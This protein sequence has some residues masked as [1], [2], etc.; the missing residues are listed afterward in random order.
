MTSTQIGHDIHP[1]SEY[2]TLMGS[3]LSEQIV[4]PLLIRCVGPKGAMMADSMLP[5]FQQS[6]PSL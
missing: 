3:D 5:T 4:E 1:S 6:P 2:Q